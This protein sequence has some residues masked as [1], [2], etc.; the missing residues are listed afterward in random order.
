MAIEAA[1]EKLKRMAC[2]AL[3]I[4]IITAMIAWSVWEFLNAI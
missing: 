3:L 2:E 1:M 4:A